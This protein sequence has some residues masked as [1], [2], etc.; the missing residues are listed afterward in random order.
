[1]Q[2]FQ[3]TFETRKQSFI[4]TFS[5]CMTIPLTLLMMKVTFANTTIKWG[6][7]VTNNMMT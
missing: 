7:Y 3:D 1:M 5:I 6:E 2:N 4:N